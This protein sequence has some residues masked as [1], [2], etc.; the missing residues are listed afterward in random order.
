MVEVLPGYLGKTWKSKYVVFFAMTAVYR[1]KPWLMVPGP[2]SFRVSK[3][4]CNMVHILQANIGR[5]AI[6]HDLI[7]QMVQKGCA[8]L[9]LSSEKYRDRSSLSKMGLL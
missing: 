9:M 3:K 5:S 6:V 4:S 2:C 7:A 8:N 1:R